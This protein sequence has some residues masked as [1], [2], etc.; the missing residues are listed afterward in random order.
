MIM[1]PELHFSW[2][3]RRL[4]RVLALAIIAGMATTT[5]AALT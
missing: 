1:I 3:Q 4:R 5:T 2:Q